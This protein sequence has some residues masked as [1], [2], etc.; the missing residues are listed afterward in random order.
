MFDESDQA[1]LDNR[2]FSTEGHPLSL[3]VSLQHAP[4]K[5]RRALHRG[6]DLQCP[7]Y[8]P[9]HLNGLVVG[10]E[11]RRDYEYA[12]SLVYGSGEVGAEADIESRTWS[13]SGY[14]EVPSTP[15]FVSINMM[16]LCCTF[17]ADVQNVGIVLSPLNSGEQDALPSMDSTPLSTKVTHDV[18]TG[19]YIV[20][21]VSALHLTLRWRFDD[22]GYD[23]A[24]S[25]FRC[26]IM[27]GF[28]V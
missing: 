12:R 9:P 18:R 5:A 4:P 14:C 21:N 13:E 8:R 16:S 17:L 7:A 19:H 28:G 20:S 11:Q 24:S 22:L 2:V 15:K 25:E 10:I 3:P 1:R 6:E 23:V 27:L 26:P